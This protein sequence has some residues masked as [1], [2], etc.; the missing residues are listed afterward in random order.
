MI[1][2]ADKGCSNIFL[3]GGLKSEYVV[4]LEDRITSAF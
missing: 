3:A 2:F 1:A 4:E